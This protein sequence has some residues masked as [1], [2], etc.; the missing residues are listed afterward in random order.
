MNFSSPALIL[1][2][3]S[4]VSAGIAWLF[5]TKATRDMEVFE[6]QFVFQLIGIP[7]LLLLPFV[8][9]GVVTLHGTSAFNFP[10]LI[11]I[12][13]LQTFAFSL[14]FY[15]LKIGKLAIVV[16]INQAYILVPISLAVVFLQE[17]IYPL[18]IFGILAIL[19]GVIFLGFNLKSSDSTISPYKGVFPAL[20][21]SIGIGL[22]AFLLSISSRI[23]GWYYTSLGVRIII[24][25][26]ILVILFVKKRNI[27][28]IFTHV[29]W[30]WVIPAA[31][32]DTLAFSLVNFSL[33]RYEVS[34]VAAIIATTPVVST[35]LAILFLKER[36]QFYQWIGF[37]LVI[38]GLVSLNV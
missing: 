9:R 22:F 38:A 28:K 8:L 15:A 25:S 24:P 30:K 19:V 34:Y 27:I 20:V 13:V 5:V 17:V 31:L 37:L 4:A 36:L 2:L 18:K 6:L 1:S 11:G 21:S 12:G 23:N 29:P 10:L 3:L 16:P 32:F 33:A 14:Y 7:P 35:S 26:T